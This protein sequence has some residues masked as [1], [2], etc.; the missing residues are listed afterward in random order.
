MS[1]FEEKEEKVRRDKREL[2]PEEFEA[3]RKDILFAV[4]SGRN[5]KLRDKVAWILNHYPAS[6][7]SDITLSLRYWEQFQSELLD[8]EMIK[9][10]NL[11]SLTKT[12]SLTRE[13]ARI[14]NDYGL[15]LASDA[16]RKHRGKLEEDEWD[17]RVLGKYRRVC[18]KAAVFQV[19]TGSPKG[20][21]ALK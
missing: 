2:S 3:G 8:G 9:K 4:N 17:V 10:E 21:Q 12:N 1:D 15:Y 19:T 7:D 16:V 13:R 14:Q 6:R 11:F 20:H 5:Q 18:L